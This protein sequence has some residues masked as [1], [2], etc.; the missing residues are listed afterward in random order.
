MRKVSVTVERVCSSF[1]SRALGLMFRQKSRT[2]LFINR[3]EQPIAVHMFFVF[4]PLDVYWLDAHKKVVHAEIL[5]PFSVSSV[6]RAQ[7]ILETERG[8]LSLKP[9]DIVALNR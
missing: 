3:S 4:F 9:G 6:Y 8:L 5:Y 7:Y 1:L 2:T